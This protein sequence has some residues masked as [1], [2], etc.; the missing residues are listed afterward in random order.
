MSDKGITPREKNY[1]QWYLDIIERAEL[2]ENSSVR[3]CMV[4][5]PYGYA[6]WEKIQEGLDRMIKELSLIHIYIF[7]RVIL[8]KQRTITKR[9]G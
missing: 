2:A 8:R 7:V 6:I 5:K 3:G 1:S 4:M 9:L